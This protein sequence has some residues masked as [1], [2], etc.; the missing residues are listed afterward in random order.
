MKWK[1]IIPF[2]LAAGLCVG[3]GIRIWAV[4]YNRPEVETVIYPMGEVVE[5]LE[6]TERGS[7][8]FGHTGR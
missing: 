7:G 3:A 5:R 6:D 2:C 8:G 4:N 1:K